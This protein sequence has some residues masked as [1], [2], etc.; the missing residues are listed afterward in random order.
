MTAREIE[1]YRALRDTIRERSTVRVWIVLVGLSAWGAL[2]VATGTRADLPVST[3]LPLLILSATFEIVFS[4]HTGVERVGR[5][6]QV[7]FESETTDRGW[8]HQAMAYGRQFPG[9][10]P[11]PLFAAYF[12]AATV[13]N[14]IPAMI[15]RPAP[16]EWAVVG[17]AHAFVIG[18]VGLAR[19]Q[20]GQQRARDLERFQRLKQASPA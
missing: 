19:R 9:S 20:A 10:G 4:L 16:I 13:L 12:W 14:V 18:R 1:E 2:T 11:D 6:V 15:A 17:T 3:L 7:F 5:Y 8:E